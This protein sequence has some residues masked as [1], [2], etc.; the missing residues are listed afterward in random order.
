[1]NLYSFLKPH[2][3]KK[4]GKLLKKKSKNNGRLLT[5]ITLS[6]GDKK[7]HLDYLWIG[8]FGLLGVVT[9][10]ASGELYVDP[11]EEKWYTI[12]LKNAKSYVP[13][14]LTAL[15][16]FREILARLLPKEN[17]Y[18]VDVS[19]ALVFGHNNEKGL[20]IFAPSGLGCMR[21]KAFSKL[22]ALPKFL[23]GGTCDENKLFEGINKYII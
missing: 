15:E 19:T 13:N 8:S 2:T 9:S 7:T 10:D 11:R 17:L 21:M 1:V 3:L 23:P 18:R 4:V 20:K 12:D 14:Q 22:V 5:D 16:S 6:Y